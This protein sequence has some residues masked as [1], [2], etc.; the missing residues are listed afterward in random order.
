MELVVIR[1]YES[2]LDVQRTRQLLEGEGIDCIVSSDDAGGNIP[3]LS[4]LHQHQVKVR[5]EDKER[6]E[7]ILQAYGDD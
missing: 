2:W 5:E 7:E 4:I 3:A 6:A 1:E